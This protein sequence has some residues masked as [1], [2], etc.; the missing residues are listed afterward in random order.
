VSVVEGKERGAFRAIL[1]ERSVAAVIALALFINLGTGIV[2]PILPL[3]ARSLGANYGEIGILV[4]AYFFAR[5]LSD[6]AAGPVLRWLGVRHSAVSGLAVL[7]LGALATA[8]SP[9]FPVAALCWGAAGFGA[10]TLFAA[11]YNALILG[12]AKQRMARALSLFYGAFNSGW[13]AG[14]FI[15]GIVAGRFGLNVP[16]FCLAAIA[17]GLAVVMLR[18]LPDDVKEVSTPSPSLP[19]RGRENLFAI[20][21]FGA[22]IVAVLANLWMFGAV[23]NTLTPLFARDIL[24]LSTAGIGV[25]YAIALAAEFLVYYPAGTWADTR[26]R[27]FVLIPSFAFLCVATVVLGW[28][29]NV[30]AF[31]ALFAIAGLASGFAGVP[32]AAMLA[33][34]VPA[35]QSARGVATFRFGADLGYTLGPLVAGLTAA[36]LGFKAAFITAGLPSLIALAVVTLGPETLRRSQTA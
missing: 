26:G 15:G 36:S 31:A 32:P 21:G 28:S 23:F 24:H 6:V 13:V 12:V 14:G 30:I 17:T 5:L 22:S 19:T 34:V 35:G 25:L 3:Y 7:A 18:V 1:S 16:L 10:G 20:P 9:S 29:P 11:M 4:G 27:R 2:L 33:D 8:I